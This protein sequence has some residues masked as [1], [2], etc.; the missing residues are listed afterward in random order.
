MF[1]SI[2]YLQIKIYKLVDLTNTIPK[3][4]W[5]DVDIQVNSRLRL[6]VGKLHVNPVAYSAITWMNV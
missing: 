1:S 6:S 3:I 4:I 5:L 2:F